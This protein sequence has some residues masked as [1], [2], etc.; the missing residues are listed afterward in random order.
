MASHPANAST[1]PIASASYGGINFPLTSTGVLP[2]FD[3]VGGTIADFSTHPKFRLGAVQ[4]G[5]TSWLWKASPGVLVDSPP[6]KKGSFPHVSSASQVTGISVWAFGRSI[7]YGYNGN[8]NG[9]DNQHKHFWD[10]GLFIGQF[11]VTTKENPND[12]SIAGCAHNI[13]TV[14][15]VTVGGVPYYYTADE[16]AHAAVHRWRIDNTSSIKDLS[17]TVNVGTSGLVNGTVYELEPLNA[18]TKRLTAHAAG[19]TSGTNVNINADIDGTHQ[20]W[21]ALETESGSGLFELV[22]LHAA[23]LRLTV[24]AGGT[25]SGTNVQAETVNGFS[26][27]LWTAQLQTNGS[28]E[29]VPLNTPAMRMDVNAGGTSNGTNVQIYSDNNTNSQ[30]WNPLPQ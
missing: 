1:D 18:P 26:Q 14:T 6:D 8:A 2:I 9:A 19:A 16:A 10:N 3:G 12:T 5:G 21:T 24:A 17:V 22:P 28:Y 25:T 11:G 7:L 29:M 15:Q 27:Q 20:R 13:L 23:S 4:N 30:R